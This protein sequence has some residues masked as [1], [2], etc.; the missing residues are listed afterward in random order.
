MIEKNFKVLFT[1]EQ[2]RN[3][4][5]EIGKQIAE[6]YKGEQL[7]LLGTLKGALPW[8]CDVM[9]E[10]DND[11]Q[12]DFVAA[13]SYGSGT[14]TSG[15]V[16]I[17]KDVELDIYGKHVII[18]EDIIDTGTT[19]KFLKQHISER[20]PKSIKICTLLDKPERRLVD[21]K[22]DYVGFEIPNLFVVGYGLDYDQKYRNLP[23][24]SYLEG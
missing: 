10:I 18:L 7:V 6:E 21:I 19:L 9:K 11:L 4:A 14:M 3:R 17:K 15:V 2:I 20:N 13:S 22:A 12:I 24:V 1:E 16:T 23:Y 5:K 8:M